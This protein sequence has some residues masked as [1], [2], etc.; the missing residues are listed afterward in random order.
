MQKINNENLTKK[1]ILPPIIDDTPKDDKVRRITVNTE[2]IYHFP[3]H[4]TMTVLVS[5]S[6]QYRLFGRILQPPLMTL[7]LHRAGKTGGFGG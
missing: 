7:H 6:E 2:K 3:S 1:Y 4:V 5:L